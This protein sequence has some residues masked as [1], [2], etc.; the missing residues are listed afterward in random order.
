MAQQQTTRDTHRHSRLLT[1]LASTIVLLTMSVPRSQGVGGPP[2]AQDDELEGTLEVQYEDAV[3]GSRLLHYLHANGRRF[4]LRFPGE[5]SDALTTGSVVRARGRLQGSTL[6]LSSSSDLTTMALA[7]PYTFGVQPT[8]VILI[9]FQDNP[10]QPYTTATAQNVTF[11]Q[12]SNFFYE[13]SFNQTSL[14]GI[15]RGWYTIPANGGPTCDTNN[16]AALADQA[17][18][19]AG[20]DLSQYGRRVYGFP[21][22]SACSWWGLGTIGGGTP[23]SPS[24]AWVNGTYSLRVVAHEMGHNFGAYH[25]RSYLCDSAA[26]TTE[27]YGD[28][29]DIMGA[30]TGHFN[31]YQKERLGW[32]NYGSSP[33]IQ[34]V[35]ASGTYVLEPYATTAAGLPKALKILK[36]ST[37]TAK[38]YIYVE[39]RTKVGADAPHAQ[40][41]LIHTGT[42]TSGNTSVELDLAPTTTTN[43]MILDMGQSVTFPTAVVPVT[44]TTVSSDAGGATIDVAMTGTPCTY[45]LNPG[46]QS[47][48]S[49]G[50]TGSTQ[51]TAGSGCAWTATSNASWLTV[52]GG[53]SGTGNGTVSFSAAANGAT[54]ARSASITIADQVF[55]VTQSGMTCT[56]GVTPLSASFDGN[57]G[58][59]SIGVTVPTGCSWTATTG[60]N[61]ITITSGASGSASGSVAY[62]VAAN[63]GTSSRSGTMTVAGH[64][65][66]INQA[67][68]MA[69]LTAPASGATGVETAPTLFAWTTTSRAQAYYLNV[70]TTPGGTDLVD[71]GETSASS[72][73]APGL[74][75]NR[76]LYARIWTKFSKNNWV[77][78]DSTFTTR[79][80]AVFTAP[81]NGATDV[82]PIRPITWTT[83]SGALAYYLYVGTTPGAKDIINTGEIQATSYPGTSLPRE[84]TLYGRIWTKFPGKW[85]YSDIQFSTARYATFTYPTNNLS[86]VNPSRPFTWTPATGAL[87]YRLTVGISAGDSS[88]ADT[89]E[90]TGTSHIVTG[91][92]HSATLFARIATRFS[93]GWQWQDI[94]FTTTRGAYFTMPTHGAVISSSCTTIAWTP[95]SG[96]LSYY[97]YLGTTP[98]AKDLIDFGETQATSRFAGLLPANQT[99]YG[100]IWTKLAS[101]W[102]YND[103]QF[104]TFLSTLTSPAPNALDIGTA[105]LFTWTANANVQKYYLYVGDTPGAN[106]VINTGEIT[107]TSYPMTGLPV[108][109]TLYAKLWTRVGGCWT[110]APVLT[111]R[112]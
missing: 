21:Q 101:G 50:G 42:D 84:S 112:P 99:L 78:S 43:D 60:A 22:T 68:Q 48:T 5:A 82:D 96:A 35:T 39:M 69:V 63:A 100:R 55:T 31:A 1:F 61:W 41:V 52:T 34:T 26:C 18:A 29:H 104:T 109:T 79:G 65:V 53:A 86:G 95:V 33:P 97:L 9:N 10:V 81:L 108:G 11:T 77:Y 37:P 80:P 62:S 75:E 7:T 72:Y 110:A 24:R 71:T 45:A 54:S 46:S 20:V 73:S 85:V 13:N 2:S 76:L 59:G 66:T 6:M 12:T 15:V 51:V 30:V 44:I 58:T 67:V 27:E 38:N 106:N 90:V 32:L 83:A 89:G 91:L 93:T 49:A 40:G 19:A 92:P 17:A 16:W 8:L 64:T 14:S 98:G 36:S 70:G 4:Q 57:G 103:S 105:G 28:D 87:G 56:Y 3:S 94:Q 47:F 23:S 74:P 25:S 107:Q 88:L 111:F 102:V